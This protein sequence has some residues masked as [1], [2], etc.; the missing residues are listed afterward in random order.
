MECVHVIQGHRQ[1][2]FP[3][4]LHHVND[5]ERTEMEDKGETVKEQEHRQQLEQ[6]QY[7]AQQQQQHKYNHQQHQYQKQ[8]EKQCEQQCQQQC[9]QQCEQQQQQQCTQ[10][11]QQQCTQQQH[12]RQAAAFF[13]SWPTDNGRYSYVRCLGR[14]AY[15]LVAEAYDHRLKCRV[16]IKWIRTAFLDPVDALRV[17]RE[18]VLLRGLRASRAEG[19][20][21]REG[22]EQHLIGL[23]NILAPPTSP[24]AFEELFFVLEY[25]ETNLDHLLHS[26]QA[27]TPAHVKVFLFQLLQALAALQARHVVHRDIKQQQQQQQQQQQALSERLHVVEAASLAQAEEN[28]RL[29]QE[30]E[31]LVRCLEQQQE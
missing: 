20:G 18:V 24:S 13:R 21:V 1:C 3:N 25:K 9:E 14:G 4:P 11:Q 23:L 10:Q 26:P 17:Y 27:L 30:Q 5:E 19:K 8:Q 7:R 22:C 16:A 29:R 31:D 15:A 12:Q 2:L 28:R 6:K